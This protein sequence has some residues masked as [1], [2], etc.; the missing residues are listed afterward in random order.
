MR[1][2]KIRGFISISFNLSMMKKLLLLCLSIFFCLALCGCSAAGSREQAKIAT[3]VPL[4]KITT[5]DVGK[6]D[7]HLVQFKGRNVLIDGGLYDNGN[8]LVRHLRNDLGVK[9]LDAVV[10]THPHKDH[11]GGIW[12]VV[13]SISIK[14]L[15]KTAIPNPRSKLNTRIEETCRKKGIQVVKLEAPLKV[16]VTEDCYFEVLW[17]VAELLR[18]DDLTVG[19][20]LNSA[21][22]RLVYKD[23]SMMFTGDSYKL[24][25]AEMIKRYPPQ[26]LRARVLKV[27]HHTANTST[28]WEWLQAVKPEVAVASYGNIPGVEVNK[29]PNKKTLKRIRDSKIK[30]YGTFDVGDITITSDGRNFEVK[31]AREKKAA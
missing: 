12:Q 31:T 15:Y 30:F 24:S 6:A 1:P 8:A 10:L 11:I 26:Q 21:V 17:P 9:Q 27:A 23:F 14:K 29:Y 20:N 22:A 2:R 25:E 13:N 16:P 3:D 18:D 7:A 4:L 28:S 5:L 19:I